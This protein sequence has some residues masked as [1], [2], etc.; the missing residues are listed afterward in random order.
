MVIVIKIK[1]R[2]KR[3]NIDKYKK[4]LKIFLFLF[5]ICSAVII[6]QVRPKAKI[7]KYEFSKL[8]FKWLLKARPTSCKLKKRRNK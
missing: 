8:K 2:I 5:S 3:T 1:E 6:K 7:A 4:N